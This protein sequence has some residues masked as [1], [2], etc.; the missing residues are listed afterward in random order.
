MAHAGVHHRRPLAMCGAAL[1]L[2]IG[3]CTGSSTTRDAAKAANT[4]PATATASPATPDGAADAPCT[5]KLMTRDLPTWA[6]EG[7]RGPPFNVWPYVT[8]YR[9]DIVAVLFDWPLQAPPPQPPQNKILWVPK[10]PSAGE[11]TV[12]AH[13]VGTSENTDIGDISFG[14]SE[15]VVPKPGCW[16]FTLHWSGPTETVDIVY[17]AH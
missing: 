11:L 16:R 13:L 8:S 15:V 10:D 12:D 9:G 5:F 1:V 6:R 14:P 2:A 4:A 7:F 17:A 3:G